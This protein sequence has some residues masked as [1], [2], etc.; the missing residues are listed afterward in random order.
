M[1]VRGFWPALCAAAAIVAAAAARG[2]APPAHDGAP[3]G[4]TTHRLERRLPAGAVPL[5]PLI[6]GTP[7]GGALELPPGV[8]AAPA[9]I[10]RP[11]TLRGGPGVIV[12]GGGV[13][14]VLTLKA[15]QST[16]SGVAFR[17]SGDRHENTDACIQVRGQFNIIKDNTFENCLFGVDLQ[18]AHNAIIRRNRIAS[19]DVEQ[20]VRGDAVRIWYSNDVRVEDNEIVASRDCVI[21]YSHGVKMT[22]NSFSGGRYGV[23]LMYAHGNAVTGNRFAANTVGVFLMY[24]N[25]NIVADNV[26]RY[27]QGPSGIGV[28]FKESSGA[29][30]L[31][32]DIFANA[33][34]LFMDASPYDPDSTNLFEGNRIAYN[35]VALVMHSDWEGNVFR[36]N[37][38]IGNHATVR[39]DGKGG[40]ARNLWD[41]N[42]F[43]DYQG[44]DRNADGVGDTPHEVW[45]WADGLWADVKDA[46]FFRASPSVELL[47]I[48]ERMA[49]LV[50]PQLMLRDA[51]P[52]TTPGARDAGEVRRQARAP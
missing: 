32:N 2:E 23:H 14:S 6:D 24:S 26:I 35:G 50:D 4:A 17:N 18:Q 40:A 13:G 39:V 44:F 48:V 45:R 25:D 51:R 9:T 28:G 29:K 38:F 30:I 41:S 8:Y 19:Q 5:Q 7:E 21:W 33:Q 37:D 36:S 43:D 3:A 12:D 15:G 47:D 42:H 22:R 46:Q 1:G 34:G 52:R 27:S 11:M 16:V 20:G 31:R 10:A 49:S